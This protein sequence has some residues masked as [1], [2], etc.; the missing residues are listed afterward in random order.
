MAPSSLNPGLFD[1]KPAPN[2]LRQRILGNKQPK[3]QT[4][5]DSVKRLKLESILQGHA[6]CVNC[7]VWNHS[8]NLL[9]SGS[10][11]HN[12]IIWDPF[13]AVQKQI[14]QT[15][16]E[17]NIFSVKFIPTLNDRL[18]ATCASDGVK[19]IDIIANA[20][21]LNCKTC[22]YQRVKRLA[23]HPNEPNLIWSSSEDGCIRQYDYRERHNCDSDK[24]RNVIL[25][26]KTINISLTAKCLAINPIRDEMLAV[27]ANDAY[28]RLFDR[29]LIYNNNNNTISN[30]NFSQQDTSCYT[31]YFTPGHLPSHGTTKLSPSSFGTTYLAFNQDGSEL[32]ANIHAEQIYL[33]NTYEPWERYKSFET[34]LKPLV[35][36]LPTSV[37]MPPKSN[38]TLKPYC[39]WRDLK[40]LSSGKFFELPTAHEEFYDKSM[41]KINTKT[42]LTWE[43]YDK[44]NQLL[45][46]YKYCAKLYQ[47]RSSALL[48]RGWKGDYYQVLRDS[49]CALALNPIDYLCLK[50]LSLA[51]F[52][53]GANSEMWQMLD[54]IKK[55]FD[56]TEACRQVA[57]FLVT[58]AIS[59]PEGRMRRQNLLSSMAADNSIDLSLDTSLWHYLMLENLEVANPLS[60]GPLSQTHQEASRR[61]GAYDYSKRFCGHCNMN[62]DIKEANFFG[63]NGEFI[64][65]GSDDGAF[66]IW[67]K[68]TTNLVKAVCGDLQIL[69]CL[70]P[71]PCICMLATS[72]IDPT[73]KIWSPSG[74]ENHDVKSL[75][76]RCAQN[77]RYL[78]SDPLEAMIMTLYPERDT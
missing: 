67:D 17:G 18:I 54:F 42:P 21:V 40:Q 51:A 25:D 11:D 63:N 27:G 45:V 30:K 77:Q 7:L 52:H 53:M 26:L 50:N 43:D 19:V 73:V 65:G 49:C 46:E 8:G 15:G 55:D 47:L 33:F 78:T 22:N 62:T 57:N 9:A 34:T 72:G 39:I 66:Y 56:E 14:I 23:T 4:S 5:I 1:T 32:L 3:V 28:I 20:N 31:T 48:N 38:S 13:K 60:Q 29:R 2:W 64:V 58:C 71:H 70:Q 75:D 6:G 12:V 24:K 36:D 76:S 59:K 35:L 10:D 37:P 41:Q 69:N 68:R 44:I 16:H 61:S 74:K